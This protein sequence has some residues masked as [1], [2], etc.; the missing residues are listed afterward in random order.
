MAKN[1]NNG[2]NIIEKYD[3]IFLGEE[4]LEFFTALMVK[5]TL[6]SWCRS[7][8]PFNLERMVWVIKKFWKYI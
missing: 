8:Q 3:T 4:V 5:H 6:V 2:T 7:F 1:L